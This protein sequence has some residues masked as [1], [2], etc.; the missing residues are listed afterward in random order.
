MGKTSLKR[1]QNLDEHGFTLKTFK[2]I[3]GRRPIER[4][5][6]ADRLTIWHLNIGRLKEDHTDRL[7][8][9][10]HNA[11]ERPDIIGISES[12]LPKHEELGLPPDIK[13]YNVYH[14]NH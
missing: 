8:T 14:N 9:I 2:S 13:G 7:R 3:D 4:Q 5:T 11:A 10:I 12:H 6:F 1:Q